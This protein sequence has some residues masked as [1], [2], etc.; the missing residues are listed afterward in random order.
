MGR[1]LSASLS[2]NGLQQPLQV[3]AALSGDFPYKLVAGAHRFKGSGEVGMGGG[4]MQIMACDEV[5]VAA[6]ELEIK[7]MNR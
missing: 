7:I 3:I 5:E 1:G 4:S 2:A 6:Q